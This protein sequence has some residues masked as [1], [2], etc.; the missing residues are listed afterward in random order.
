MIES[1]NES[2]IAGYKMS[3]EL[4]VISQDFTNAAADEL[5][6]QET[7]FVIGY[8]EWWDSDDWFGSGDWHGFLKR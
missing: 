8:C 3:G 7:G 1:E 5:R 4:G 2:S 6:E